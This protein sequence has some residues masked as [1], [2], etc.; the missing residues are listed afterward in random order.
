VSASTPSREAT[1]EPPPREA[2]HLITGASGFIGGRLARRL[3]QEGHRVRCLVRASSDTSAL[4][5]LD[6]ELVVGD[7]TDPQSLA[8][9]V[10]GCDYVLH[11]GALVSDW[12]TV[13]E[14]AR[15]NVAGTRH[16]L[17]A[18]VDASVRRFVHISSTDV[19]G[20]PEQG[21]VDE[22]YVAKRFCNWYAQTKLD[23]EAE[24]RRVE[25][26]HGLDAVILRPATVYG[27]GSKDVIGEIARAIRGRHM[28]LIDGGRPNAGLCYVENLIDAA[29]LALRHNAAPGCA[30]NVTDGL[31]VTWRA[32]ADDL[33]AGLDCPR[34]RFSLPYR[35]AV[36]VGF[37]LEHGYRLVR[38]S[39]GL[40]SPPLLSRQAVQVL[41]RSQEFSNRKL[42]DT[43]GWEPRVGYAAG[44]EATL[45]WLATEYFPGDAARAR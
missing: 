43:L 25:Q 44:L 27:P 2:L 17:Q 26:T 24:V 36:S 30:F 19:Y 29:L 6:V 3:A 1:A 9:A 34:V 7:L 12:A 35:L 4:A 21:H 28:L 16:L 38:R 5:Q 31:D 8:S 32:L 22:S 15:I 23:A 42:R 14:I 18:A 13:A 45:A 37:S 20:Y 39:T 11:C 10:A 41:G 33:A 40:H